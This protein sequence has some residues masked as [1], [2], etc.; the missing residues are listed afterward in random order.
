[1]KENVKSLAETIG[2]IAGSRTSISGQDNTREYT[3]AEKNIRVNAPRSRGNIAKEWD[4]VPDRNI[5]G[6]DTSALNG[7]EVRRDGD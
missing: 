3:D 2:G 1:M 7:G 5:L 6:R 4:L